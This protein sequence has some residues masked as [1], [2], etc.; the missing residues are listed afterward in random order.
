MTV[1]TG[2]DRGVRLNLC[3]RIALHVH[4]HWAA[5]IFDMLVAAGSVRGEQV[6]FT[7]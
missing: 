2:G 7:G 1:N 5:C 6:C 4:V 3:N